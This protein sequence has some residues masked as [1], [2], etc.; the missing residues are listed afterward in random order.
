M[1]LGRLVDNSAGLLGRVRSARVHP[2]S[3]MGVLT[4]V[5]RAEGALG[6]VVYFSL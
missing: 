1:L 2:I 4:M 6:A 3:G 5:Q